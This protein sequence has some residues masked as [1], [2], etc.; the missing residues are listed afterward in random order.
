MNTSIIIIY[1]TGILSMV[2]WLLLWCKYRKVFQQ[3]IEPVDANQYFLKDI[4]FIGYGFIDLF[5]INLMGKRY[6]EKA[7]KMTELYG[8]K[9]V[10]FY[11]NTEYAAQFTYPITIL[12]I[13][14]FISVIAN[15]AAIFFIGII[16]AGILVFYVD[17]ETNNKV[18]KKHA[19]IMSDFP[20]VLS[21]M[22]LLINAGMPLRDVMESV[23]YNKEG[24]IYLELQETLGE[25]KNGVSDYEALYHLSDRCDIQEVKKLASTITQNIKK[26]SSELS[27]ALMNMSNEVW[28]ERV[29]HVK[30]LGEKASAKLMIPM[31]IIFLAILLMVMAPM[32]SS[33]SGSL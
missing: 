5:K 7:K 31:I 4:F 1:I 25:M 13:G 23:V 20:H 11:T 8:K 16:V 2:L 10:N 19:A 17:Y 27:I 30:E 6:Q 21:K 28:R 26:G 14:C 12:P 9:Y 15:E 29:G 33:M 18:E 22:A 32:V 24:E 3:F